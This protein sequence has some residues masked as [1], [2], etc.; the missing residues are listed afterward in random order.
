VITLLDTSTLIAGMELTFQDILARELVV[1]DSV[2][3]GTQI[4]LVN[5]L[6]NSYTQANNAV[7]YRSISE[8]EQWTKRTE[9]DV[10]PDSDGWVTTGTGSATLLDGILNITTITTQ[11]K[12][13][14]ISP[15]FDEI[16]TKRIDARVKVNSSDGTTDN[17]AHTIAIAD[18]VKLVKINLETDRISYLNSSLG[19]TL[20][21]LVDLQTDFNIIR[22]ELNDV[23]GLT[24]FVNGS[25]IGNVAYSAFFGLVGSSS[26]AFGDSLVA[27]DDSNGN[28]DYDYIYFQLDLESNPDI[29][30][31]ISDSRY[32]IT[33]NKGLEQDFVIVEEQTNDD[34]TEATV[35]KA[36]SMVNDDVEVYIAL[37]EDTSIKYA[38]GSNFVRR[39]EL[40][41]I[42]AGGTNIFVKTTVTKNL[43]TDVHTVID[44]YGQIT[45]V[46]V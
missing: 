41:T 34:I 18:G 45:K 9:M 7:I 1:I 13:Y 17:P 20:L 39:F 31:D 25:S 24:V 28:V 27:S 4:T 16:T 14:T 33:A 36:V 42:I 37:T 43:A 23:D 26:I 44:E 3:S 22:I 40:D 12:D 19:S 15:T 29:L 21:A 8:V 6:V 38:D 30:F 32:K 11:S 35:T 46:G 2:D 5:G 10:F